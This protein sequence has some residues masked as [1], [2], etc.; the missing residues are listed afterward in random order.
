MDLQEIR[1]E[2]RRRAQWYLEHKAKPV[3][4]DEGAH[5]PEV[6]V[7]HGSRFVNA[8]LL[9]ADG[10]RPL[11]EEVA[12]AVAVAGGDAHVLVRTAEHP[13]RGPVLLLAL[14]HPAGRVLWV[15]PYAREDGV[16]LGETEVLEGSAL[17][18]TW[19]AVLWT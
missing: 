14:Q 17:D 3:V 16:A 7:F 4:R 13:A 15:T 2:I 1:Q 18:A 12:E 10:E 11:A 6:L 19:D 8:M 5:W 9:A